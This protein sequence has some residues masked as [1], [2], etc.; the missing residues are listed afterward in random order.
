MLLDINQKS[1]SYTLEIKGEGGIIGR[2]PA[3]D[4]RIPFSTISS[5]HLEFERRGEFYFVRDLGSTNGTIF[6]GEK[7]F[8]MEWK[9]IEGDTE[10]RVVD[11]KLIFRPRSQ[12]SPNFTMVQS[13]TLARK[14]LFD[15][16]EKS[17]DAYI[18]VIS[19]PDLGKRVRISEDEDEIEFGSASRVFSFPPNSPPR[20]ATLLIEGDGFSIQVYEEIKVGTKS[21]AVN[22]KIRLENQQILE[23]PPYQFR[24]MDPLEAYFERLNG[25]DGLD[26][27]TEAEVVLNPIANDEKERPIQPTL[28]PE[29]LDGFGEDKLRKK[30]NRS[31]NRDWILAAVIIA[32]IVIGLTLTA[33]V[34]ML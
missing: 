33:L 13:G 11:T 5:S 6:Q 7:M 34:L 3:S 29:D 24:F 22:E 8:P 26:L 28:R 16:L 19:G 27:E 30:D 21:V 18:E 14:L 2:G 9:K 4:I 17:D 25:E 31:V 32:I 10:I 15:A 20:I 23:I 12:V 1:T